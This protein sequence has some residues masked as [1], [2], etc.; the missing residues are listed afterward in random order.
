MC[1]PPT[2]FFVE[3]RRGVVEH[4]IGNI[5]TPHIPDCGGDGRARTG[6]AAQLCDRAFGLWHEVEHQQRQRAIETVIGE[7]QRANVANLE[8]RSRIAS[9]L[10]RVVD[11]NRREVDAGDA[12]RLDAP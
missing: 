6:D 10:P 7:W 5:T 12:T 4:A 11:V 8:G 1:A 3:G 2:A 9:R